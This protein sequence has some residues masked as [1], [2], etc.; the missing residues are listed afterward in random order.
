MT[1]GPLVIQELSHRFRQADFT[2]LMFFEARF[3]ASLRIADHPEAYA[4]L[5]FCTAKCRFD[6]ELTNVIGLRVWGPP[7][8]FP[9]EAVLCFLL[10]TQ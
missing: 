5:D 9:N 3:V 10:E 7:C 8:C 1:S 6:L 4:P 2:G